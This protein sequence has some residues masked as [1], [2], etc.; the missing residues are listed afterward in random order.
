[1]KIYNVV[2]EQVVNTGSVWMGD[3]KE[4][5]HVMLCVCVCVCRE[6]QVRVTGSSAG[7]EITGMSFV[8]LFNKLLSIECN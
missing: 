2:F 1:M 7:G 5:K 3:R 8:K 4:S 6:E